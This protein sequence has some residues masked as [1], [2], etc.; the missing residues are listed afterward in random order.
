MP[1]HS[2][3][4]LTADTYTYTS[5]LPCLAHQAA[6]ATA[7]LVMKA[8]RRAAKKVRRDSRKAHATTERR[9]TAGPWVDAEVGSQDPCVEGPPRV[10]CSEGLKKIVDAAEPPMGEMGTAD[11]SEPQEVADSSLNPGWP[12]DRIWICNSEH[13]AALCLISAP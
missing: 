8:A 4:V 9:R 1:G 7:N 5:V 12:V 10:S 2:S 3:I 13:M 11:R 6:E